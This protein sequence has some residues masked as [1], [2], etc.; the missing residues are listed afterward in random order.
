MKYHVA[1][2]VLE[3]N[4]SGGWD[5][6]ASLKSELFV[7]ASSTVV[8]A[9][10]GYGLMVKHEETVTIFERWRNGRLFRTTMTQPARR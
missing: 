10:K 5:C 1:Q 7:P 9:G 4:E 6:L 8:Q 2:E 3:V